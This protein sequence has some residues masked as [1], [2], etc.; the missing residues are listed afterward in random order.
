MSVIQP[1]L[2]GLH[3]PDVFDLSSFSPDDP[4][5]FGFLLQA[6]FGPRDS[7]GEESFDILVCTPRRLARDVERE[8][9]VD[10]RH[11]LIVHRFDIGAIRAFLIEYAKGCSGE[12]WREVATKLARLGKW[13]F[14]DYRPNIFGS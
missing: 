4:T 3:S 13:E 9:I 10:G 7:E 6:M 2:K 12:T 8:G 11:H 1:V 14:E 5:D